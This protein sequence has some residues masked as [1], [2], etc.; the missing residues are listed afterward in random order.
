[1]PNKMKR[2]A[3]HILEE[4]GQKKY[5]QKVKENTLNLR[6]TISDYY[7]DKEISDFK[8]QKSVEYLR[9]NQTD[10]YTKRIVSDPDLKV[11]YGFDNERNLPYVIHYGKRLY[12]SM[13]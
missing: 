5:A 9:T 6:N 2:F 10:F 1:M 11:K 12:L 3:L 7:E 8:M 4:N 13:I